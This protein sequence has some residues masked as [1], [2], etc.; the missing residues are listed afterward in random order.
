M[1]YWNQSFGG[2]T[3]K[4]KHEHRVS[5]PHEDFTR[6]FNHCRLEWDS[7]YLDYHTVGAAAGAA[8]GATARRTEKILQKSSLE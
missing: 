8:S 4:V 2:E 3:V 1:A 5:Q 6:I 7:K